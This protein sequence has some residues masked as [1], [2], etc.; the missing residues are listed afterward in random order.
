MI[1]TGCMGSFKSRLTWG[2]W[3]SRGSCDWSHAE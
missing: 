3:Q 2:T 1:S